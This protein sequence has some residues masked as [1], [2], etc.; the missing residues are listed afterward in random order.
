MAILRSPYPDVEIPELALS[1]YVF[2]HAEEYAGR[3]VAVD[4]PTG[5]S[6]TYADALGAT[7]LFAGG[8]AATGF[9]PGQTL[10]IMAPNIP[11][12]V[13]ALHGALWA[14]GTV[15]TVNPTYK[16]E[17]VAFQLRDAGARR[18]VTIGLFVDVAREAGEQ[19]DLDEII[20]IGDA[21][22][23]TTNFF[24]LL[25]HPPVE[26]QVEVDVDGTAIMPYSSGTTGLAKGVELTHRNLVANIEQSLPVFPLHMDDRVIAVLPFFHIYGLQV[27][28]NATI[29]VG[30]EIVTVPRFDLEQFLGIIQ[31]Q[32]VTLAYLVPPIVLAMAKHPLVDA[33]DVSSLKCI[34][35]G[36]APLGVDVATAAAERLGVEIIQGYGLTETS[37]VTHAGRLGAHKYGT[38]GPAVP[39]TEVRLVDPATGEDAPP[40]GRGEVW[41]RGPQVM[42]GYLNRPDATSATLDDE[43]WLHTGDIGEVDDEGDFMIVDRLKELIKYKG[44]QVPPAELE[45]VLL[46]HPDITDAAVIPVPDDEAGEIPKAFVVLRPDTSPTPAEIMSFVADRVASYKKVRAVETVDEIP[47]SASGKILRRVLRDRELDAAG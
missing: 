25:G 7:K 11:E 22:D 30:A 32:K 2:E 19:A 4:G 34:T 39:N 1:A 9:G 3:T 45:A 47:K 36:A 46:S 8:L 12:Y 26:N 40:G 33:Y 31:D 18:M 21:V 15:T 44:F 14:G 10:A 28:M 37:P 41:I 29:R 38:I 35:S 43:G 5:R 23:G 27:V 24:E 13:V 17:E 42:K 16:A 6:Y 20:V